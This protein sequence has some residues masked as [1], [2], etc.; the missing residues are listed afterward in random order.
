MP[1]TDATPTSCPKSEVSTVYHNINTCQG[2]V[3]GRHSSKHL[4][5]LYL[6]YLTD[7]T[8]E[9]RDELFK[10]SMARLKKTVRYHVHCRGICPSF[11][12]PDIFADDSWSLA[13]EKFWRGMCSLDRP[14][15]LPVWLDSVAYSAVVEEYRTRVRR[16]KEGPVRWEPM[17]KEIPGNED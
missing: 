5:H 7:P 15:Q 6:L 12:A 13:I 2:G 11:M 1:T 10:A 14:R 17:E 8:D 4:T 3:E 16:I 9:R